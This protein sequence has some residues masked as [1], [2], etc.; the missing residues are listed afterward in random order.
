MD[1]IINYI[2]SAKAVGDNIELTVNRGG[3]VMD[4]M[5]ILQPRP[6]PEVVAGSSSS[7]PP[8]LRLPPFE[9]P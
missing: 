8:T 9:I 3:K 5:A 6:S 1:D 2:E 7:L 4:L